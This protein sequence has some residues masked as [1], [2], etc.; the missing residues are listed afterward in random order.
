MTGS[1]CLIA[2]L[3]CI[4]SIFSINEVNA[5][6]VNIEARRIQ[7]DSVRFVL[8]DNFTF[9][10]NDK[11]G[12]TLMQISNTLAAQYKTKDLQNI[13]LALGSYKLI[14]TTTEDFLNV[15][16]GHLRYNR[17][18]SRLFRVESFIQYQRNPVL[19]ISARQLVG[20]GFRFKIISSEHFW[21]YLGT[22][23]LYEY[24]RSD[25][26]EQEIYQHRSSNYVSLTASIPNSEF[27]MTGTMYYQ[28]EYKNFDDY[29]VLAEIK[30]K[31]KIS[32][33]VSFNSGYNY[34]Y[35]N[36]TPKGGR[37]YYGH[38]SIGLGFSW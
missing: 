27:N 25:K 11:N 14:R 22:T 23:Y 33:H 12:S 32:N 10:H 30:L 15:L 21:A 4:G 24:E 38:T 18:I 17:K 20:A 1:R 2:V 29:R 16:F 3:F 36:E 8:N 13:F 31:Y 35:D 7:S 37:Q 26:F 9:S 34:F 28:P 5:Q 6:L 19:D